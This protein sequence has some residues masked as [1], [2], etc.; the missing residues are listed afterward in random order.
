MRVWVQQVGYGAG[1]EG[2]LNKGQPHSQVVRLEA[3]QPHLICFW[4][5]YEGSDGNAAYMHENTKC[6]DIQVSVGKRA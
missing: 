3:I 1:L 2:F 5:G 6:G 4:M